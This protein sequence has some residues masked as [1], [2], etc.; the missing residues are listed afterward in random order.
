MATALSLIMTSAAFP[1][2]N[3][4]V[5]PS[6]APGTKRPSRPVRIQ[7]EQLVVDMN[8]DTAEFS[9]QVR[10]VDDTSTLAADSVAIR[11]RQAGEG[12]NQ[13]NA[14]ISAAD[15]RQMVAHG[16]VSIRK[17]DGTAAEADEAILETASSQITLVGTDAMISGP[18]FVL[19]GG[20][21]ILYRKEGELTAEGGP[22]GRVRITVNAR[23]ARN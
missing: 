10:I 7:S 20:R 9:G 18:T 16:H 5:E 15:I 14:E 4:S 23:S 13:L 1:V 6:D 21:I 3:R 2:E 17:T 8:G 19:R 22:H 11:F 12:E